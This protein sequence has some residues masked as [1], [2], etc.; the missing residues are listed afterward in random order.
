MNRNIPTR[1]LTGAALAL[2]GLAAAAQGYPGGGTGRMHGGGNRSSI[3]PD[4]PPKRAESPLR[5]H[6]MALF[7]AA[8]EK[9]SA[10]LG[11]SPAAASALQGF[12]RDMK[13]FA[14]LD[15]RRAQERLG[16]TQGA[17]HATVDVAR[18]LNAA[19]EATHEL[20]G[21]AADVA[22]DW[23]K[24]VALLDEAQRKRVEALYANALLEARRAPAPRN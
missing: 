15:D 8:L 19:R 20:D 18:D 5:P 24:L 9:E 22:S 2:L 12:I 17:V 4:T 7:A 1:L 21:A 23:K 13:D 11:L 14:G 16:W 3:I 6:A 10:A